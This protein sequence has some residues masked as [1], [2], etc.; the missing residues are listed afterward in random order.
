MNKIRF[1][2]PPVH[3]CHVAGE[4]NKTEAAYSR[5]LDTLVAAGEIVAFRFE[6]VRFTLA[7]NV[8]GARNAMTY[9]PDFMVITDDNIQFHET[10]GFMREDA[11]LKVKMAAE[12]YPWF[13]WFVIRK[14]KTGWDKEEF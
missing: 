11:L 4:M 3:R 1:R 8:S 12:I 14:T 9:T 2:V 6:A 13:R 10:K 7:H 5:Q